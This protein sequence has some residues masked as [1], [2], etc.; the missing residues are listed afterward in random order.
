[1]GTELQKASHAIK[2]HANV[3]YILHTYVIQKTATSK[4]THTHS[5]NNGRIQ[6]P[7]SVIILHVRSI[8]M[9]GKTTTVYVRFGIFIAVNMK[10][11]SSGKLHHVALVRTDTLE[12]CSTFTIR[13][14]RIGKLGTMLA[15][16]SN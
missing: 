14:K 4:L 15:V 1:M 7:V 2:V 13:V 10:N 16:T 5:L 6:L 8:V 11:V 12:E 9:N 3:M